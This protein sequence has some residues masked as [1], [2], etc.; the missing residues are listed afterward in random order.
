LIINSGVDLIKPP[1]EF[2]RSDDDLMSGRARIWSEYVYAYLAGTDLQILLGFGANSWVSA[3]PG[4]YAHNTLVSQLYECGI[5]GVL[6]LL[7][8]WTSMFLAVLRTRRGPRTKLI[9]AHLSFVMLNLA[10]MPLWMIEGYIFYAVICG[11]TLYLLKPQTS[12]QIPG[13]AMIGSGT[14]PIVR[15]QHVFNAA[16]FAKRRDT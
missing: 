14:H 3:F 16:R 5:L 2:S 4:S 8:L 10:T 15:P 13:H 11:Y 9:A 7:Y 6:S 12:A 1:S